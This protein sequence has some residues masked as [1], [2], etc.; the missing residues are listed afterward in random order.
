V[1]RT[2]PTFITIIICTTEIHLM[3]V[4]IKEIFG[5]VLIIAI[6]FLTLCV[7]FYWAQGFPPYLKDAMTALV[8]AMIGGVAA[9]VYLNFIGLRV[10]RNE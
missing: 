8:T 7:A 4:T 9:G 2:N 5:P 6:C 3:G 1:L 10:P